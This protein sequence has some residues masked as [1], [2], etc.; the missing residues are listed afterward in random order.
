MTASPGSGWPWT[1]TSSAT[2]SP[3]GGT[4][5][6]GRRVLVRQQQ[7]RQAVAGSEL[8]QAGRSDRQ[9]PDS[10]PISRS[11]T[12]RRGTAATASRWT[13]STRSGTVVD[14][15]TLSCERLFLG[16]GCFGT[17]KLLMRAKAKGGLP[18]LSGGL[19]PGLRQRR[20]RL[21]DSRQPEREHQPAPRRP[22]LHRGAQL[23]E[24]DPPGLHD[25]GAAAAL[26]AGLPGGNRSRRSSSRTPTSAA[27]LGYDPATDSLTLDFKPESADAA[28]PPGEPPERVERRRGRLVSTNITGHQ[29]GG[30]CMGMV[31]D[32][33]G[34]VN[35]YPG[36]Y[37]VD[38]ALIPGSTTCVNP[39]RRSRP[40]P[41]GAWRRSSPRT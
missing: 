9:G 18:E 6:H 19:G 20:R 14:R 28:A 8:R 41:S 31:C 16:A 39:V 13:S 1:G 10:G 36:L 12:S 17:S 32:E 35:G 25:A 15:Q 29:L 33:F 26:Q 7:R 40:S 2:R 37:V 11:R 30:A 21:P 23:R 34:R 38:G 22:R 4:V 24:P 27:R 3:A 5:V